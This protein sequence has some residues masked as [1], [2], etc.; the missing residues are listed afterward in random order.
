MSF[1]C[2]ISFVF[3]AGAFF[4]PFRSMSVPMGWLGRDPRDPSPFLFHRSI[5]TIGYRPPIHSSWLDRHPPW[6]W[7]DFHRRVGE[8]KKSR[9]RMWLVRFTSPTTIEDP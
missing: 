7:W 9:D 6:W 4:L 1:F 5:C 2:F 3:V 8:R